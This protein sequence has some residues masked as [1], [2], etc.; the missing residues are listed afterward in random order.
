[1][2]TLFLSYKYGAVTK[3]HNHLKF[4]V[5][6][7]PQYG[8]CTDQKRHSWTN[9]KPYD[10]FVKIR[11][12]VARC[13]VR[14]GWPLSGTICT[15]LGRVIRAMV[16]RMRIICFPV[17]KSMWVCTTHIIMRIT[18]MIRE[19]LV[20][21]AILITLVPSIIYLCIVLLFPGIVLTC[22]LFL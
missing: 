4:S 2:Q 17:L 21:R 1:M 20:L 13:S 22:G 9:N 14:S 16:P 12:V 3:H 11:I 15:V 19:L 8:V 7:H 6:T 10:L 18:F 5:C